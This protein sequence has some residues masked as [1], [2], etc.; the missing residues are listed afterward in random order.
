MERR[1]VVLVGVFGGTGEEEEVGGTGLGFEFEEEVGAEAF[2]PPL[3]VDDERDAVADLG[4]GGGS[5]VVAAG[6]APGG[7]V[8]EGVLDFEGVGGE[9]GGDDGEVGGGVG[10]GGGGAEEV[11]CDGDGG[12]G[13]GGTCVFADG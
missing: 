9:E 10:G 3:G 12:V 13:E 11:G 6:V 5:G 1:V 7:F 2:D 8:D 4:R